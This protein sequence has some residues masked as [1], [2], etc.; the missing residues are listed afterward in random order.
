MQRPTTPVSPSSFSMGISLFVIAVGCLVLA[1]WV[2]DNPVLKSIL[3]GLATMKGNTALLFVLSGISLWLRACRRAEQIA[4][5]GGLIVAMVGVVTIV[6]YLFHVDLEID[7]ILFQEDTAGVLYPGR[8]APVT[9]LAFLLIGLALMSLDN[10][11][12]QYFSE[13]LAIMTFVISGLALIGYFYGVSSLYQIGA[14]SSMA[15][16][17]ALNFLLLSIG[18]IFAKP[19]NPFMQ[20]ILADTPGGSILRRFVPFAI[21]L[22]VFLGWIGLWGQHA[23]FYDAVFGLTLMVVMLIVTLTVF[24]WIN[25][26]QITD[27]DAKRRQAHD[28]FQE[29]ELRFRSTLE[30]MIEGCQII[31]FDWRYLYLNDAAV[32]HSKQ[33]REKLLGRTMME[34]YPGIEDSALFATLQLCMRNRTSHHMENEFIYPDGTRGWFHLSIQPAPNGI[35]ILSS[36]VTQYKLAERA[37]LEREMKLT[38]LFEI[39]P[40]GISILDQERKVS[41]TNPALKKILGISEEGL[42]RGVYKNRKYLNADGTPM[43]VDELASSRALRE[44]KEID[45]VETGVVKEDDSIVWTNVSAVP[46]DFPDWKLV[47]LTSDI[48]ERKQAEEASRKLEERFSKAFRGSPAGLTITSLADG[49]FIDVNDS[50]LRMFEFDREEV[51]G[52]TSVEL[53]MLSHDQRATPIQLLKQNGHVINYELQMRA[54]S[55][56]LVDVLFSTEQIELDGRTC[57]LTTIIDITERKKAEQI[58]AYLAAVVNSSNDAIISKDLS[59]RVTSWNAGAQR[60]FGYTPDEMIGQSIRRLIPADRLEEEEFIL[61]QVAQD[62]MI[63]NFETVRITQEGRHI[64]VLVT[65]SPIKDATGRVVGAS[66]MVHDITARK[67]AEAE[68]LKLNSKL[69]RKVVERTAELAAANER[70]HQLSILDELTGL[71]NRRGF[72]MVAEGHLLQALRVGRSLL[73][74]YADLDGLKQ[75]NDQFGHPAGDE[76]LVRVARALNETF[77][78]YD[79][80]ARLGGD[81]FIVLTLETKMLDADALLARLNSRLEA[82]GLAMSVGVVSSDRLNITSLDELIAR[83]DEAMYVRKRSRPGSRTA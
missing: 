38:T 21:V 22:P 70:L 67:Q 47:L 31:G 73:A 68:I 50:F 62:T 9:A 43:P 69:E 78:E 41:Y 18:M 8:M 58:D 12:G 14:Y 80:K 5:V 40:V 81:E 64:D 36:D 27:M 75:I 3:P 26:A 82:N 2:L 83:A 17:T 30:S 46:V 42:A 24:I 72:L 59:G 11:E 66:K 10:R 76:A 20:T 71:Y 19:E 48:T 65:V 15:L 32:Q 33:T 34:C 29:S 35:F 39:L 6:E 37:L 7:Q 57:A 4:R 44:H 16:H 54:R 74:F 53:N 25:A 61:K 52:H 51:I 77:R 23:G 60:M 13:A 49:G 79:I 45:G 56:R 28:D 55:G 1:G 63:A